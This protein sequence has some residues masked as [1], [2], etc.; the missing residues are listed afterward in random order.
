[1]AQYKPPYTPPSSLELETLFNHLRS[2][3][4]A[5]IAAWRQKP[6]PTEKRWVLVMESGSR[7]ILQ[8]PT[9]APLDILQADLRSTKQ[10][11]TLH[12][13][14]VSTES[15][16]QYFAIDGRGDVTTVDWALRD[17]PWV[18][19]V[20][21]IA[22]YLRSATRF[23]DVDEVAFAALTRRLRVELEKS[24]FTHRLR[25]YLPY[26][27][28]ERDFDLPNSVRVRTLSSQEREEFYNWC[29]DDGVMLGNA[30][31]AAE[32]SAIIEHSFEM[33]RGRSQGFF[34][35]DPDD[36]QLALRLASPEPLQVLVGS[37]LIDTLVYSPREVQLGRP[38]AIV[39]RSV[40][41]LKR[42]TAQLAAR[43]LPAV[44]IRTTETET[45]IA[46][47]HFAT[48]RERA[49]D[50]FLDLV[51]GLE[52]LA[53]GGDK[54]EV[55]FKFRQRLAALIGTDTDDRVAIFDR[56]NKIYGARSKVAHGTSSVVKEL[57]SLTADAD[58]YLR[59][60]I[61]A[62]LETPRYASIKSLDEDI[63]RG[64]CRFVTS[65]LTPLSYSIAEAIL[66]AEQ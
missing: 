32:A 55:T 1:M 19:T 53:N 35:I 48:E 29:R 15:L 34:D 20:N 46:R 63:L 41:K 30:S 50:R 18:G 4:G 49:E 37:Q 2:I 42:G 62:V 66:E 11:E 22:A 21:V 6:I 45:A 65:D 43:M 36:Y 59:R 23:A 25:Y 60:A 31:D 33:P 17:T 38:R 24:T 12:R 51:V 28:L 64:T 40:I 14:V 7:H 10:F 57:A 61:V 27:A 58:W 26:V 44:Q 16:A 3:I 9:S 39:S 56:A 52:S 13:Y 54:T 8:R 47:L 5:V